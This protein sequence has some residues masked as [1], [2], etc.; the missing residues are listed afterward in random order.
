MAVFYDT[1]NG[2]IYAGETKKACL[3]AMKKDIGDGDLSRI[4]RDIFEVS[5]EMKMYVECGDCEDC[6][7]KHESTLAEEYTNL[8]YGYRI[9]SDNC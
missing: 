7:G 6:P 4:K 8:G 5:G 1:G 9:A 3:D 2:D